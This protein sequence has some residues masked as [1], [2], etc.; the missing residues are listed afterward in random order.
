M[1]LA[2]R[3]GF[4]FQPKIKISKPTATHQQT[5]KDP[6][7]ALSQSFFDDRKALRT[8]RLCIDSRQSG[9]YCIYSE[10]RIHPVCFVSTNLYSTFSEL[11][12]RMSSMSLQF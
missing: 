3:K 5:E 4:Q 12:N 10:Q 6:S 8:I 1:R 2:G 11:P 9:G 7:K